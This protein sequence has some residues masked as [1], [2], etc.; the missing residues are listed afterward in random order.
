MLMDSLSKHNLL[1]I[2][3]NSWLI[4]NK[5]YQFQ[6]WKQEITKIEG[7]D[8]LPDT[9]HSYD[10][11]TLFA[12]VGETCNDRI[13]ISEKTFTKLTTATP[14]I[15]YGAQNQNKSLLKY[16]FEL[17]DEIFDYAFDSSSILEERIQGVVDNLLSV[18]DKNWNELYELII[19]KAIRNKKRAF[20]II[21]NDSFIPKELV[22]FYINNRDIFDD[23]SNRAI[24]PNIFE[25]IMKNKI[26][27]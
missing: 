4:L 11:N 27:I 5:D 26:L 12:I 13:F 25:T 8:G 15:A 22:Q 21:E 23:K 10:Y 7:D 9:T 6:N 19:E 18:K 24:S 20:E 16:G 17:Y 2:G 1:D 14:F 3:L